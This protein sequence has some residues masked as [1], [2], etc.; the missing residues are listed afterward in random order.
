MV[1]ALTTA[2]RARIQAARRTHSA[3]VRRLLLDPLEPAQKAVPASARATV[4]A[5]PDREDQRTDG[6]RT[7]GP[8]RPTTPCWMASGGGR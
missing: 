1:A 2:G 5:G 4:P 6:D 3:E 7:C 8:T